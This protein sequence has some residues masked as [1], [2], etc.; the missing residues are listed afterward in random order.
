MVDTLAFQQ[1]V[2]MPKKRKKASA[3]KPRRSS[4][5]ADHKRVGRQLLPPMLAM[6]STP[7]VFMHWARDRLP[8]YLWV[9]SRLLGGAD[10]LP[11]A[12]RELDLAH[13][14]IEQDLA[15]VPSE[16]VLD[17]TL[18]SFE[19]MPEAARSSLLSA[20]DAAGQFESFVPE[21][22]A[23][24][25]AQYENAPGAWLAAPWAERGLIPDRSA[26][27]NWLRPIIAAGLDGRDAL[28]THS[29]ALTVR[30]MVKAG[31]IHFA[32]GMGFLDLLPRYPGGTTEDESARVESSLR[33][34]FN[35]IA[36]DATVD[37]PR[38]FWRSNWHLFECGWP[39]NDSPASDDA[40]DATESSDSGDETT[41]REYLQDLQHRSAQLWDRYFDVATTTAPDLYDPDRFE[42]LTGLV[43]RSVRYVQS[44]VQT[45]PMWTMEHGAPILRALLETEIVLRYLLAKEEE[46]PLYARFKAFGAGK[47]KLLKLHVEEYIDALE[48]PPEELL[49][50]REYLNAVVN[51]DLYEEFQTVDLGGSF[52]GVDTR[53]MSQAVGME[54][55]YRFVFAPAS[56]NVHGEWGVIDENVF[57]TCANPLHRFHRIVARPSPTVIG[58]S[59]VE[60]IMDRADNLVDYYVK[61][62]GTE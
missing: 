61:S 14:A 7:V 59:F 58:P 6:G 60:S 16:W 62:V 30:Q 52:A 5:I 36:P 51:R 21:G 37:W 2:T 33:A 48:A 40:A 11:V 42:V 8:D 20:L 49:Q 38:E 24:A 44:F 35:A 41:L 3:R 45:P 39:D 53:R 46:G 50:Y 31:R 29:K 47:I 17:G 27:E 23:H 25:V 54:S 1:S 22:F 10:R 18:T 4:S 56:S 32:E 28:A 34:M 55:D 15:G 19:Q 43:G 12:A 57:T 13:A 26:A 9:A